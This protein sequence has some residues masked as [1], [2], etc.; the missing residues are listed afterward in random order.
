MNEILKYVTKSIIHTHTYTRAYINDG[1]KLFHLRILNKL[2]K[3]GNIENSLKTSRN[4]H[5]TLNILA[6][7]NIINHPINP[8]IDQARCKWHVQHLLQINCIIRLHNKFDCSQEMLSCWLT[9]VENIQHN[10]R[11]L[12]S[13]WIEEGKEGGRR[14]DRNPVRGYI[15]IH[16]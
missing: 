10:L 11:G 5:E 12:K 1:A 9:L 7:L 13:L 8:I 4:V 2:L 6:F 14:R 3:H 15:Y 16:V